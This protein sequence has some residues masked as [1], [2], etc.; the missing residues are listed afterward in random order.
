MRFIL[1]FVFIFNI[2]FNLNMHLTLAEPDLAAGEDIFNS[3]CAACHAGG[4]NAV[5]PEKTLEIDVLTTN[6]MNSV[7]AII[8]Q[9]TNGKNA[10]PSFSAQLESDD[11]ENVANYVLN[12]SKK[13]W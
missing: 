3:K 12:Q 13:G 11:I 7:E 10:M 5:A 1:I 4:Q 9:V 6:E 2:F 8:K